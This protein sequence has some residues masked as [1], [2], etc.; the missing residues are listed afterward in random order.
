MNTLRLA[1]AAIIAGALTL[2]STGAA[3]AYP[4]CEVTIEVSD[5]TV[6]GGKS[7]TFTADA[8][9]SEG[10]FE[11]SYP[12]ADGSTTRT[13]EGSSIS[14]SFKTEV[15]S[16]KT[17]TEITVAFT[18]DSQSCEDSATVTVVPSGAGDGDGDAGAGDGDSAL[19]DTGG[20]NLYL[21]IIGGALL[22]AGGGL[23]YA[24]RRRQSTR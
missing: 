20:S 19:P 24:A 16:K 11:V 23:T 13:G 3:Q 1:A 8:G 9:A 2:L 6:V 5:S 12:E 22:L 4:D 18:A 14:G 21:L 17:S 7:F 15:V 10:T